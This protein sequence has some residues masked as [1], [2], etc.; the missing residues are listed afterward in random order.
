M[1][2]EEGWQATPAPQPRTTFKLIPIVTTAS[3]V[4]AV[5]L[6][7][8]YIQ[9]WPFQGNIIR[10]FLLPLGLDGRRLHF[11]VQVNEAVRTIL[12]VQKRRVA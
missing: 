3:T 9:R 8:T 5:Q 2:W 1:W 6:A 11:S 10:D 4:D 12:D 7:Q